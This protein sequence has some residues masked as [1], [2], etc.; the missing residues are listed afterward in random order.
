VV[1][2]AGE[3]SIA[4]FTTQIASD[5]GHDVAV[6]PQRA[7]E[8]GGLGT[9]GLLRDGAHPVSC[10]QDVLELIGGVKVRGVAA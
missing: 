2:G 9:F 5:L 3:R 8:P 1:V 6:V 10:A 4:L 7:T